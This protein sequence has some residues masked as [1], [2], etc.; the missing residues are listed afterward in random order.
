[1]NKPLT[2]KRGE[3]V[4]ITLLF[5]ILDDYGISALYGVNT[6][7]RIRPKFGNDAAAAFAV[8]VFPEQN[9]LLLALTAEQSAGLRE[10]SYIADVAFTR[11]SDGLVQMSGDIAVEII[12]GTSHVG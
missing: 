4:E 2:F 6:L 12:K 11:L 10:G 8:D 9:R 5:D 7:A 3:T 1:M